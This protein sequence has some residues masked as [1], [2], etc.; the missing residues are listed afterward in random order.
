MIRFDVDLLKGKDRDIAQDLNEQIEANIER[1]YAAEINEMPLQTREALTDM[2]KVAVRGVCEAMVLRDMPP[3]V[4]LLVSYLMTRLQANRTEKQYEKTPSEILSVRAEAENARADALS[5]YLAVDLPE[6]D[7]CPCEKCVARRE[8]MQQTGVSM[9]AKVIPFNRNSDG[10]VSATLVS[11]NGA[12][13]PI[14][15]KVEHGWR[16]TACSSLV[17]R[18]K[19]CSCGSAEFTPVVVID[20]PIAEMEAATAMHEAEKATTIKT[21]KTVH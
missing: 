10:T 11:D 2:E 12:I 15:P 4:H 14:E 1:A 18:K 21:N 3:Y 17:G 9:T 13:S 16:C 7:D 19:E 8:S 20:L 6:E 5:R